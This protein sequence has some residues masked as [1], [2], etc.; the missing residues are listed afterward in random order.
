MTAKN[1]KQ[2]GEKDSPA[3]DEAPTQENTRFHEYA[4]QLYPIERTYY[5]VKQDTVI[6][7]YRVTKVVQTK[8]GD[9]EV[10]LLKHA[11]SNDEALQA[12]YRR[13]SSKT[14]EVNFDV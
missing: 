2:S 3:N 6:D 1:T 9:K 13:G 10:T 4:G 7:V 8:G 11:R 12:K 14:V 5:D